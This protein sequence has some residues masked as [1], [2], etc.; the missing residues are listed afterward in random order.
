MGGMMEV[1][2]SG[3]WWRVHVCRSGF[4]DARGTS[5][6]SFK[7]LDLEFFG[8]FPTILVVLLFVKPL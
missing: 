5:A 1:E 6:R 7:P 4:A 8:F 3:V 2:E